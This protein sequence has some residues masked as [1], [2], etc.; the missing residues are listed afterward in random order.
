M[1]Q[2]QARKKERAQREAAEREAEA[3]KHARKDLP[4]LQKHLVVKASHVP[5]SM[6]RESNLNK[7]PIFR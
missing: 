3:Q 5:L 4:W 7:G 1:K 6:I 2:E